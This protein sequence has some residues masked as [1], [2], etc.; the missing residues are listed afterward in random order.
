M[1]VHSVKKR[2]GDNEE[3]AQ[4]GLNGCDEK[5]RDGGGKGQREK[6]VNK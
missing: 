2:K 1:S 5:E 6:L 4:D 3:V